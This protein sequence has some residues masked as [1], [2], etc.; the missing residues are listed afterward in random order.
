MLW[1]FVG[2]LFIDDSSKWLHHTNRLRFKEMLPEPQISCV[3]LFLSCPFLHQIL[4]DHLLESSRGD[5]SNKWSNIGFGGEITQSRLKFSSTLSGALCLSALHARGKTLNRLN[6][7][8]TLCV[9][10]TNIMLMQTGWIQASR[11]VS[12][13]L[14]CDPANHDIPKV[15]KRWYK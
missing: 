9:Q 10:E 6:K 1:P 12:R 3:F 11:L 8:L 4:F 14:A 2:I 15:V 7:E 5:D 13:P